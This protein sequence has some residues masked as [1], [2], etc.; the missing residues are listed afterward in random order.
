MRLRATLVLV[1]VRWGQDRGGS[2]LERVCYLPAVDFL[3]R[4][5]PGEFPQF[6]DAASFVTE[7]F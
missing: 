4:A 1:A 5:C 2:F 3:L 7:A 6:G